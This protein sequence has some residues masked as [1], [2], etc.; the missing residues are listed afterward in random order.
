[1]RALEGKMNISRQGCCGK[2]NFCNGHVA[3]CA[4]AI[5]YCKLEQLL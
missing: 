4:G 5:F 2:H 3:N 1:L